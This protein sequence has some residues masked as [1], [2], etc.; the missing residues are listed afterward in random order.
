MSK[1]EITS[2]L[3]KI[4][5]EEHVS[6]DVA[7]M[8]PYERDDQFPTV[9]AHRPDYVVRP[10][11]TEEIQQIVRIAN[12]NKIPIVPLAS[13][14]NRKGLCIASHGGILLDMRRM[15][16]IEIDPEMMTAKI[17]PG[18]NFTQLVVALNKYPHLRCLTPD[19]P[20][21][22]SVLAN[23]MLRGIYPTSTR[24]GVDHLITMEIVL[25]NGEILDTGSAATPNSPGPYCGIV[26]GPDL[27]KLF[28]ANVGTM[29]VV[30]EGRVRLYPM[31]EKINIRMIRFPNFESMIEPTRQY[32]L[33]NLVAGV[34]TMT[35]APLALELFMDTKNITEEL[36]ATLV[37]IEG[38]HDEVEEQKNKIVQIAEAAGGEDMDMPGFM[39]KEFLLDHRYMRSFIRGWRKGNLWGCSCYGP[40]KNVT[41]YYE[42]SKEFCHKNDLDT[43][44]FEALPMHPFHGEL[45]YID[46]CVMWDGGKPEEVERVRQLAKD[47]RTAFLDIGIYGFFRP[48][49][50][51]VDSQELGMYG[52]IW[53][54]IKR[55]IDPNNIMNPGKPPLP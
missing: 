11:T 13:G 18:V 31:P 5:G 2:K 8:I 24:Y 19:A 16:H 22:A 10:E 47:I 38:T 37:F 4:V 44:H 28:Q 17:G 25:P 40:L 30:T 14:I 53:R 29:G 55:L 12:E 39:E 33:Q 21:T 46:P 54:Q 41:K 34:W 3:V 49:P 26:N 20:A 6:D 45:T 7:D 35:F 36:F 50:G 9:P 48:F 52:E 1:P 51:T 32:A 43:L 15:T 27:T 23:Y 42:A